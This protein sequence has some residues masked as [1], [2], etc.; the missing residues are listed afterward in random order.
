[1][2]GVTEGTVLYDF[3]GGMESAAM[4]AIERILETGAIVR[5]ADTGKQFPEMADSIAEIGERLGLKIVTVPRRITFDEFLFERGGM[6]RKELADEW[7]AAEERKGHHFL[8]GG[9]L[10]VLGQQHFDERA[11]TSCSCF[12]GE[13]SVADEIEDEL[14]DERE[15]IEMGLIDLGE[16]GA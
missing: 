2:W 8:P 6:L 9:P 7:V 5:F 15:P 13:D 1:M 14:A 3:S 12:G 16:V 11:S 10:K 4:L